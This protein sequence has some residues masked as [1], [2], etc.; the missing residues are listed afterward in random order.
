ML[1]CLAFFVLTKI[2]NNN[3]FKR[4]FISQTHAYFFLPQNTFYCFYEMTAI[5]L[6]KGRINFEMLLQTPTKDWLINATKFHLKSR[7]LT[8]KQPRLHN[9]KIYV[10]FCHAFLIPAA[11]AML[12]LF[13]VF[14]DAKSGFLWHQ[15]NTEISCSMCLCMAH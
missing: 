15:K 11:M 10:C 5:Y 12:K 3:D 1:A 14:F 7:T 4:I 13:C 9:C 8:Q 2:C 6:L